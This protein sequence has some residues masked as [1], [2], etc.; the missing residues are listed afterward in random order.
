MAIQFLYCREEGLLQ[1][2]IARDLAGDNLYRNTVYCIVAGKAVEGKNCITIH[3][4]VL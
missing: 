1:D 2:C 4:I 3:C